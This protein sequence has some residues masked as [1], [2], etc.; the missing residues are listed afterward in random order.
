MS[1]VLVLVTG[2]TVLTVVDIAFG[3]TF[4]LRVHSGGVAANPL[5]KT[6][7][8]A[9]H[10]HAGV[11]VTLG[12]VVAVLTTAA[13][14]SSGPAIAGSV[15]VLASAILVPAGFFLSVLGRDPQSPGRWMVSVWIGAACLS[16][17][18]VVSAVTLIHAGITAL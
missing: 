4:L 14:V 11:L 15:L 7:F 10:A 13:G 16:V 5:Q 1:P 17:G 12:L 6:F 2:V 8:R 3:G 18:L 9:G